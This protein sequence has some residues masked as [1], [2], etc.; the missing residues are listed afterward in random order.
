MFFSYGFKN[1]KYFGR[2]RSFRQFLRFG[3]QLELLV[4]QIQQ[5]LWGVSHSHGLTLLHDVEN[6]LRRSAGQEG[7]L[8]LVL[9]QLLGDPLHLLRVCNYTDQHWA[10]QAVSQPLLQLVILSAC[11][12]IPC[13]CTGGLEEG[14][15]GLLSTETLPSAKGWHLLRV[16]FL[17]QDTHSDLLLI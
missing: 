14:N 8:S 7:K 6:P 11:F 12:H 5:C 4:V 1:K 10:G 13:F 15:D 17:L 2:D 16:N 3:T 9:S